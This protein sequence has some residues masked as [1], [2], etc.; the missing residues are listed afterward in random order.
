METIYVDLMKNTRSLPYADLIIANL[1]IEYI[2]YSCFQQVVKQVDPQVVSCV[3][4]LN[5]DV[6]F[7]SDSPYIHTF[8]RLNEGHHQM[9]E[10]KLISAMNEIGYK[11][12]DHKET[13]RMERS[14][15]GSILSLIGNRKPALDFFC[16][17]RVPV[18]IEM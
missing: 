1:F 8:D 3:I 7:V 13:C 16:T 10:T 5:T 9:D 11:K 14:S 2:G 6:S 18:F 15:F 4:Q 17:D 12:A